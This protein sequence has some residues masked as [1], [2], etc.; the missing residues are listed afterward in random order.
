MLARV[1][2]SSLASVY[3]NTHW[4][5]NFVRTYEKRP[6]TAS[7]VCWGDEGC[8]VGLGQALNPDQIRVLDG[9]TLVAYEGAW[10]QLV[11]GDRVVVSR[12]QARLVMQASE[13]DAQWREVL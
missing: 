8:E 9:N 6:E 2:A 11:A 7:V 13:F 4:T 10:R 12:G 5:G 3:R 1:V